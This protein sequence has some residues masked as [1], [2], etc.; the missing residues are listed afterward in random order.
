MNSDRVQNLRLNTDQINGN[1]V[2][3]S[4]LTLEESLHSVETYFSELYPLPSYS[5][6]HP[7]TTIARCKSGNLEPLLVYALHG[8]VCLHTNRSTEHGDQGDRWIQITE[9]ALWQELEKLSVFRIQALLLIIRYQ[10]E[11]GRFQKAFTLIAVAARFAAAMRLNHEQTGSNSVAREECRRILWSLKLIERYFSIGLPEFEVLPFE[12]I[13]IR[14][15]CSEDKFD[16]AA[17]ENSSSVKIFSDLGALG[18][19]MRLESIRRDIMKASRGLALCEDG[20]PQL[21]KLVLGF[22]KELEGVGSQMGSDLDTAGSIISNSL[23]N[24]WLCRHLMLR[25]SWHQSHCDL[26]RLLLPGYQEAA[27]GNVLATITQEQKDA[28]KLQCL[29]HALSIVRL[30]ASLDETSWNPPPLEFDTAICVY[31]A[32]RLIVF[33]A[34]FHQGTDD[35]SPELANGKAILCLAALRRLFRSSILVQPI[36][37]EVQRLID[38]FSSQDTSNF[39]FASAPS[40]DERRNP[41]RKISPIAKVQQRLAV[42][43]LLS[44]VEL[45]NETDAESHIPPHVHDSQRVE[46]SVEE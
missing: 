36:I 2:V 34:R 20:F 45:E 30:V 33:I 11:S 40:S 1:K 26:Y 27:P 32:I 9:Q 25:L 24:Q 23:P 31:H 3:R 35:L 5:F 46:A 17:L 14:L 38:A 29:K 41:A 12:S 10:M 15:P 19:C 43:S 4:L 13:Y 16:D 22:Q 21:H 39:T 42:H 6:L 37:D 8:V 28:A 7:Q 18:L 44:R